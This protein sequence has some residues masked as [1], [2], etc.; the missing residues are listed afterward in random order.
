MIKKIL[1]KITRK[2][3][4]R[5]LQYSTYI[6]DDSRNFNTIYVGSTDGYYIAKKLIIGKNELNYCEYCRSLI[7]DLNIIY[8]FFSVLSD[9]GIIKHIISFRDIAAYNKLTQL[10]QNSINRL[11]TSGQKELN[12]IEKILLYI[13]IIIENCSFIECLFNYTFEKLRLRNEEV[14]I[15]EVYNICK[16]EKLFLEERNKNYEVLIVN[17]I[18]NYSPKIAEFTKLLEFSNI[19][20][21]ILNMDN[22]L[23]FI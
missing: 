20:F 15:T 1:S 2:H 22:S 8:N 21:Y 4:D 9:G 16:K 23:K 18:N 17:D 11:L 13:R 3:T 12:R 6:N 10:D 19:N 14:D 5:Y 7:N